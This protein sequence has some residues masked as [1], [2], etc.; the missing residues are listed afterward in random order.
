M[1]APWRGEARRASAE[2]DPAPDS[3]EPVC[4]V[5]QGET[6]RRGRGAGQ[7]GCHRRMMDEP[8]SGL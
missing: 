3:V 7:P 2:P 4:L 5:T 6:G 1:V 8:V